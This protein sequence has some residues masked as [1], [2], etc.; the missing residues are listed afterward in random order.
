MRARVS[1]DPTQAGILAL[2]RPNAPSVWSLP[3]RTGL[4]WEFI[5]S[6][7]NVVL[8]AGKVSQWRDTSGNA[9]HTQVQGT[10]SSRPLYTVSSP[11]ASKPAVTFDGVDDFL[12]TPALEYRIPNT[13]F[14]VVSAPSVQTSK[15][16]CDVV[17]TGGAGRQLIRQSTA[18]VTEDF[19]YGGV[20]DQTFVVPPT[21]AIIVAQRRALASSLTC[22]GTVTTSSLGT[23][24][25]GAFALALGSRYSV[26]SLFWSGSISMI[27]QY[28]GTMSAPNVA[29]TLA[30]IRAQYPVY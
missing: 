29:T 20:I 14:V 16:V 13:L 19:L 18:T 11:N 25:A 30:A 24:V 7:A 23:D 2:R 15:A 10:L 26:D 12:Q 17:L 9:N 28:A 1:S 22:N 8:A 27:A 5:A 6:P 3:I 21:G 4:L